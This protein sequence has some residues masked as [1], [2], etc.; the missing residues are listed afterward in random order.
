M[1]RKL[2]FTLLI[3]VVVAAMLAA[4]AGTPAVQPTITKLPAPV[5]SADT[6]VKGQS[7]AAYQNGLPFRMIL[8]N[9]EVPVV[10]IM[11]AGFVQACK[12]YGLNCV[13]MGVDGNDIAGSVTLAEQ[14]VALGSSGILATIYDKAWYAPTE[15]AIKAGIPVIN[16]HFPMEANVIPGLNA[17]VAPDNKGYAVQVADAIA[18]KADCKGPVAIT[19]SSLN[20]G[21]NAV[22]DSFTKELTAK[23]PNIVVLP[24]QLETTDASKALAVTESILQANPITAAFS[25]TGGG[26][27]A[28]AQAAQAQGLKP[29]AVVIAGMDYSRENLDMV[30]SGDVYML[31][32]QPLYE[33][34]YASVVDLLLIRSGAKVAYANVL[35]APLITKDNLTPY[36]TINDQADAVV[37][38]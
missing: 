22:A 25:T 27:T 6:L 8:T 24:V 19:Q 33:E 7:Y 36:Y 2:S 1:F 10:K 4:C 28:W 13:L 32:G 3:I 23:C 5:L 38:K 21:E 14:S 17:W 9:R 37:I 20:D 11:Q 26:A 30:K 12:D 15:T 35:P 18:T 29:G 16:G 31:V 34:M